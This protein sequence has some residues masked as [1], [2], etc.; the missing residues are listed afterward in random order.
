MPK[1]FISY[2]RDDSAGH[3]GR[4]YDRLVDRF[5]RG[6]VFMDVDT[7]QPGLD[8]VDVVQEAVSACDEFIAV[9]GREWLQASDTTGGRRLENPADLVRLEIATALERGIRVLPV[10]LQGAQP[11]LS[12]DLPDGLKE[13][14]N[15]NA[16]ELSD[17]RFHSD[18]DRLIQVLEVPTPESLA[19][20][21]IAAS[22][23]R[24]ARN[25][26]RWWSL[27]GLGAIVTVL[28][29]FV[30]SS[31]LRVFSASKVVE[32]VTV[33]ATLAFE[34]KCGSQAQAEDVALTLCLDTVEVLTDKTIRFNVHWSAD[35][36]SVEIDAVGRPKSVEGD[37]LPYLE[38]ESGAKYQF[39]KVGGSA[40]LPLFV[41]HQERSED[42]WFLFPSLPEPIK[43][44]TLVDSIGEQGMRIEEIVLR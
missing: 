21:E 33:A 22:E 1:I 32:K 40:A 19:E 16:L 41:R 26:F 44:V 30:P 38:D 7:I 10:L 37:T 13:L 28:L 24:K 3:A 39:I 4:L 43:I 23:K 29:L 42:G 18:V 12:D 31:P 27:V 6:Q 2:R 9:I 8:F 11:P 35:I 5:G 17:T 20:A 14:A 34:N 25:R 15:R 36:N